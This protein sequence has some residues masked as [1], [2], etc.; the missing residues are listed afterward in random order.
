M[1]V[2]LQKTKR[3]AVANAMKHSGPLKVEGNSVEELISLD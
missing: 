3:E 2:Y 1:I